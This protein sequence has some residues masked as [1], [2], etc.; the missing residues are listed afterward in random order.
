MC[1]TT[2]DNRGNAGWYKASGGFDALEDS[3]SIYRLFRPHLLLNL[4][5]IK[6]RQEIR[7][8]LVILI[9]FFN[10][11]DKIVYRLRFLLFLGERHLHH[12]P[13]HSFLLNGI[14]INI[15]IGLLLLHQEVCR[16]QWP[17]HRNLL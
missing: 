11:T 4:L 12:M 17:I 6:A 7:I 2:G 8:Y 10:I 1:L 16:L 15:Q 9:E 5:R 13:I 3:F 14:W